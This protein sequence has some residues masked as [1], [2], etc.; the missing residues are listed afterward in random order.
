M[1]CTNSACHN[2][3][4]IGVLDPP[5][6]RTVRVEVLAAIVGTLVLGVIELATNGGRLPPMEGSNF[7]GTVRS[8]RRTGIETDNSLAAVVHPGIALR[9]L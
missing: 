6:H 9:N 7:R 4:G 5:R 1:Y 3:E 8:Y 2:T